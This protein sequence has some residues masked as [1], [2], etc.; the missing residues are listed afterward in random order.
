[1]S[2]KRTILLAELFV[3]STQGGPFRFASEQ[4]YSNPG[5]SVGVLEF[6]GRI[7]GDPTFQQ[8]AGCAI[9]GS[10]SSTVSIGAIDLANTDGGV[11]HLLGA[12]TR[13]AICVLRLVTDGD[14]YDQSVIVAQCDIDRIEQHDETI[15]IDGRPLPRPS[16]N[17][18]LYKGKA[19]TG[20]RSPC[21]NCAAR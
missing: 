20:V 6:S 15:R 4:W 7:V 18:C 17:A 3:S 5:D 19:A 12:G 11:T 9:W 16:Y 8:Q 10:Q 21:T 14:G 1:M 2:P 13:G